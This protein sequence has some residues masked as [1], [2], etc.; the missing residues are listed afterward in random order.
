MIA[1]AVS[2]IFSDNI[3]NT[4]N[5]DNCEFQVFAISMGHG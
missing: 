3:D 1:L 2:F 5:I 4:D